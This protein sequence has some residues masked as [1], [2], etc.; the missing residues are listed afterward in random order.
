[1]I[2]PQIVQW[3]IASG[4]FH[5]NGNHAGIKA[6]EDSPFIGMGV[7]CQ[8]VERGHAIVICS[9][10]GGCAM[11]ANAFIDGLRGDASIQAGLE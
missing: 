6:G 2:Q 11:C 9:T 4:I 5:K 1:M 10:G 7:H 8:Y 3:R